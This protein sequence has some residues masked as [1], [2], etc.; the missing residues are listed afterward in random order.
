MATAESSILRRLIDVRPGEVGALLWASLFCFCAMF[1]YSVLRPIRDAMGA[2]SGVENL[3]TNVTTGAAGDLFSATLIAMLVANP[4]YAALVA[5][6]PRVRFISYTYRFFQA[7]LIVFFLLF[8]FGG[9]VVQR[10]AGGVF[11]VWTSVF[12]LFVVSVFWAFMVDVFTR[13]QGT[14]LFGFIAA[15]ATVGSILGS[16]APRRSCSC[17]SS[18]SSS[19]CSRCGDCRTSRRRSRPPPAR[20][21]TRRRSGAVCSPGSSARSRVRTC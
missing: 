4:P 21:A 6:L 15:G 13:E 11:F 3:Q 10:W 12:N 1:A 9:A 8:L 5:R 14:R 18:C 16:S 19:R 7:N 20:R 2:E 17:R